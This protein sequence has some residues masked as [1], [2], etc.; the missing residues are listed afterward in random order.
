MALTYSV[1]GPNASCGTLLRGHFNGIPQFV[2]E[3]VIGSLITTLASIV[4]FG[5][6]T[7]TTGPSFLSSERLL[8]SVGDDGRVIGKG[9]VVR[10][11]AVSGPSW[12]YSK[13]ESIQS[14]DRYF[15]E[16]QSNSRSDTIDKAGKG[17]RVKNSRVFGAQL[18]KLVAIS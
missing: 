13:G 9:L 14:I 16:Y 11:S 10:A 4:V 17:V 15:E 12:T 8:R 2:L 1:K 6:G 7:E 5:N 3:N 18:N